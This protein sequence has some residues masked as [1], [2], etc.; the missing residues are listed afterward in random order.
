MTTLPDFDDLWNYGDPAG[1]EARFR[2]I[3]AETADDADPAYRAELLTQIARA[4]GLQHNFDGAHHTL[5]SAEMEADPG[6]ERARVRI[7][8]ERGRV[9]NSAGEPDE[10]RAPFTEALQRADQAGEDALAIDALH[11]LAIIDPP[12]QALRW[13]RQALARAESSPDAKARRWRASLYNNLGWTYHDALHDYPGALDLFEKAL[14]ARLEQ[15]D[16]DAIRV[17]RWCV[18]RALRSL[19]RF[20]EALAIQRVLAQQ[21]TQNGTQDGYVDE[22]IGEC[23][24]ALGRAGEAGPHFARAYAALAADDWFRESEPARLERLRALGGA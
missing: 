22:E 11:M 16:A 19:G 8:L 21:H 14:A 18:A 17:A 12:E 24:L 10:A 2:Q 1:T 20:E 9:F 13:N 5:D 15:G 23:L 4:Q 6:L 7:L 3:L